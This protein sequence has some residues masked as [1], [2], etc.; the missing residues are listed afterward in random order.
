[1]VSMR[2]VESRNIHPGMH[3]FLQHLNR[4][5]YWTWNTYNWW[6]FACEKIFYISKMHF[7]TGFTYTYAN[8]SRPI[9][10]TWL[11][12][13]D[14]ILLWS[15]KTPSCGIGLKSTFQKCYELSAKILRNK[16]ATWR[17]QWAHLVICIC[18]IF[19]HLQ[20]LSSVENRILTSNLF[21][22]V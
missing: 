5:T 15:Q 11:N 13:D 19:T 1:M 18:D 10:P 16:N 21:L 2:E 12:I 7:A 22:R 6:L 9:P 20:F 8:I 14:F 3:E 17:W 4:P